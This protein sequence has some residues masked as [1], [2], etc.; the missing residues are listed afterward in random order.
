MEEDITSYSN[1]QIWRVNRAIGQVAYC[2][3]K[4]AD[5]LRDPIGASTTSEKKRAALKETVQTQELASNRELSSLMC[6]QM[7]CPFVVLSPLLRLTF[8]LRLVQT[9]ILQR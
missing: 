7:V 6:L 3:R 5:R 1:V 9:W 8:P 2:W 4:V